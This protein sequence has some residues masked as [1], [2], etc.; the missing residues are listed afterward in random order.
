MYKRIHNPAVYTNKGNQN[1]GK[2]LSINFTY[3][4]NKIERDFRCSENYHTE[5]QIQTMI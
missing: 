2:R 5:T 3:H 1:F 4:A